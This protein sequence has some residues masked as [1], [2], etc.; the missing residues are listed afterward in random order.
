MNF[1]HLN[2][3]STASGPSLGQSLYETKQEEYQESRDEEQKLVP[4]NYFVTDCHW[5]LFAHVN[6]LEGFFLLALQLSKNSDV[7]KVDCVYFI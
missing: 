1:S 4:G 2:L 3:L 6:Q 5:H 7:L